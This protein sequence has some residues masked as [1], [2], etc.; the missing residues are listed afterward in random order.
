MI[1][2]AFMV[3]HEYLIIF[4]DLSLISLYYLLFITCRLDGYEIFCE[5]NCDFSLDLLNNYGV[6][7]WGENRESGK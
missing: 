3:F 6:F 5:I 1:D 7:G 2:Y 4:L